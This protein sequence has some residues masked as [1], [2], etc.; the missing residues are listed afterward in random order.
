MSADN[1]TNNAN[2]TTALTIT[3]NIIGQVLLPA[4]L[5]ALDALVQGLGDRSA[6]LDP[7]EK[8]AALQIVDDWDKSVTARIAANADQ[9]REILAFLDGQS[10]SSYLLDKHIEMFRDILG[11]SPAY[12]AYDKA[13]ENCSAIR[14]DQPIDKPADPTMTVMESDQNTLDN[15]AAQIAWRRKVDKADYEFMV[16]A[17]GYITSLK[18][19]PAVVEAKGKLRAYA[20]KASRLSAECSDKASRAKVNISIN[21]ADTRKLLHDL[22]DFASK[23]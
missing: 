5:T 21:D 9:A 17:K 16:A 6:N 15:R 20:R 12:Q 3:H 19:D 14:Q 13:R 11:D 1:K 10:M 7:A 18:N 8:T 2:N 23:V 22:L 4:D